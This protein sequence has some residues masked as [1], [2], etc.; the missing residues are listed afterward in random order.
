M[1][2]FLVLVAAS[3][4]MAACGDS[5][6]DDNNNPLDNAREAVE[7]TALQGRT[8]QSEC[9]LEPLDAILTGILTGGDA[10][11]KSSRTQYLF[12]G[13]NLTRTTLLYTGS[14]CTG[15]AFSFRESGTFD[16]NPEQKTA[17]NGSFM[18]MNFQKLMLRI[19]SDA[20]ATAANAIKLCGVEDWATGQERDVSGNAENLTCYGAAVPRVSLNVYRIDAGNILLLGSVSTENGQ[21]RPTKLNDVKFTAQ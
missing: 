15:E 21:E 11:V 7:D 10:L 18:D 13:A 6:D 17:D 14:D 2:K 8:F 19:D 3:L 4:F 9:V 1:K 16:I 12:Q 5:D 20:G